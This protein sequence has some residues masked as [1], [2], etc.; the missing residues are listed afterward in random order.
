MTQ[1]WQTVTLRVDLGRVFPFYTSSIGGYLNFFFGRRRHVIYKISQK[2]NKRKVTENHK[3]IFQVAAIQV[4]KWDLLKKKDLW[5]ILKM[6]TYLSINFGR[7]H[8]IWRRFSVRRGNKSL[9]EWLKWSQNVTLSQKFCLIFISS[10][11]HNI[12]IW[13]NIFVS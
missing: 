6:L 7:L 8:M 11:R 10:P 9:V 5:P 12:I 1:K 2:K 4:N 13:C 3:R